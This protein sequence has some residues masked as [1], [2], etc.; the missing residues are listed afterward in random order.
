MM[1][2]A[3]EIRTGNSHQGI[4]PRVTLFAAAIFCLI[5][6][7]LYVHGSS[8]DWRLVERDYREG[9]GI[10]AERAVLSP[11]GNWL[12]WVDSRD[13][14]ACVLDLQHLGHVVCLD[15][16]RDGT[17]FP[18]GVV[19]TDLVV[20]RTVP[21]S[22]YFSTLQRGLVRLMGG[23]S[24]ARD[25]EE[26]SESVFGQTAF[27][28]RIDTDTGRVI[29]RSAGSSF[30]PPSEDK[31]VVDFDIGEAS[32]APDR[33]HLAWWRATE[34]PG[35]DPLSAT[36]TEVFEV[37]AT[38]EGLEPVFGKKLSTSGD[39]AVRS[40]LL[41]EV[42]RPVWLTERVCLLLSFLEAGSLLPFDCQ[43]ELA[44][45]AFPLSGIVESIGERNPHLTFG[46]EGFFRTAK[47]SDGAPEVVFWA[48]Q[49]DSLHFFRFDLDFNLK[50]ETIVDTSGFDFKDSL[51]LAVTG[52]LLVEDRS[53]NR[54]VAISPYTG[55]GVSYPLPLDWEDGFRVLGEDSNGALIGTNSRLFMRTSAG[56]TEWETV[57][58]F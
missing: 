50:D 44:E 3:T 5:I 16:E 39:L 1:N 29:A 41:A 52:R 33:R 54:L 2:E 20:L 4:R 11:D 36:I 48:R 25:A 53:R 51:W 28:E 19:E 49:Q 55:E 46:P 13:K 14:V 47:P 23:L 57:D 26:E 42:G 18:V 27:V 38:S 30:G 31:P 7:A 43:A 40:R 10:S 35:E 22:G 21:E 6:V 15:P 9:R 12:V 24:S 8:N 17:I 58:L 56:R 45:A 32:L 37:F 34:S